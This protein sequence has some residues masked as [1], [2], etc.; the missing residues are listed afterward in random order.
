MNDMVALLA[1]LA[2]L[3][4]VIGLSSGDL[5]AWVREEWRLL[6]MRTWAP[7]V[8]APPCTL[9]DPKVALMVLKQRALGK[10]M[11]KQGRSLL[12]SKPYTP[13]LTKPAEEP[14]PPKADKVVPFRRASR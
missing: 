1:V 10:R 12:A 9:R 13:A 14:T 3:A 6:R 7:E 11:R 4:L 2:A 8:D 5:V